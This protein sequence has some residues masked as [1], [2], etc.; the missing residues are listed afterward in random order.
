ME[1]AVT[2]R[3]TAMF[4]TLALLILTAVPALADSACNTPHNDFDGLYCLNKIYQQADQDLNANYTKLRNKLDAPGRD[5][6]KTGQ[7]AWLRTRDASCSKREG[8]AFFVN[9][10]CATNTTI[11]RNRFLEDRYRECLSSGCLDRRLGE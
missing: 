10:S 11:D 9:L 7:L 3:K 6:L 1:A 5:A 4:R 2:H 8:A